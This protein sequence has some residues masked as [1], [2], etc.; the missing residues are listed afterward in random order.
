M[1]TIRWATAWLAVAGLAGSGHAQQATV[2]AAGLKNPSQLILAGNGSLLVSETDA[3]PNSGRISVVDAA[4]RVQPLLEGLP[5]GP[6]APDGAL[7]GPNGLALDGPTLFIANGE[8]DT[9][10]PAGS[11][12][13]IVPD[14]AGRSSPIYSSILKVTLSDDP[15]RIQQPFVLSRAHQDTLA[16]G[17]PVTLENGVGDTARL[18]LLADFRDNVPDARTIYRNSHPYGMTLHP[19]F[20]GQLFVADAGMNT[21]WQVDVATGRART[22]VRFPAIPTGIPSRPQAEA[23]PTNVRPYGDQLLVTQ[24]SG[25]PFVPNTAR[26]SIVDVNT[27]AIGPFIPWAT[28]AMDIAWEE[29]P[30]SSR[31]TFYLLEFSAALAQTPPAPGRIKRWASLETE[32]FVP[33]LRTPTC[34]ALDSAA[35]ALYVTSRS[36]GA[37]VRVSLP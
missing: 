19:S 24:L 28:M 25:V 10:V 8:G 9:H 3:P 36:E 12:G 15:A 14:P 33:A 30:G 4:G 16:D 21:V 18:E 35:R 29:R 5:S 22:L 6:A 7:D 27:G 34:M 32:I 17:N 1:T 31:P 11:P 20:P 26:V 23:V 37:T 13:T 2:F